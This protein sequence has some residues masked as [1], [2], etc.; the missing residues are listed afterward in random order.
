[1]KTAFPYPFQHLGASNLPW[2]W[3][4]STSKPEMASGVLLT[5]LTSS[6]LFFPLF[7]HTQS[8]RKFLG[9]GSNLSHN[10]GNTGYLTHCVELRIKPALPQGQ[11]WILNLLCHTRSSSLFTFFF[12][13]FFFKGHTHSTWRFPG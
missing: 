12:F 5:L 11:C 4:L 2:F 6:L 7:S 13:F 8:I 1:M 10:C 3:S 9:Q